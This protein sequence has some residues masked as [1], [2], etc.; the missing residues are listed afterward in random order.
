MFAE[1][2]VERGRLRAILPCS[3]GTIIRTETDTYE[4]PGCH[5]LPG[6]VDNHAHIVGLGERLLVVSLHHAISEDD[7][8]EKL[9]MAGP[10]PNGWIRAMGWNQEQ[11]PNAQWPSIAR[12]DAAFPTTPVSASRVDGH[13]MWVN[14]AALKAA[15]IDAHGHSGLLIDDDMAPVFAAI[16]PRTND[17]LRSMILAATSLCAS[18]GITEIHDM[19]VAEPWLDPFRELAEQGALP[20]RVQSFVRAHSDEWRIAGQLPAIGEFVRLA[21]VKYYA[22]GALGSRGALL[23]AP[24]HDDVSTSGLELL[25]V[26]EM[27][28]KANEAIEAGWPCIAIHAIGDAA[29]RNVL[30][31]Y[32]LIRSTP[33]GADVI[34]RIEHAQHVHPDDVQRMA[35]L[36]VIACVQPSHCMSDAAMAERRLGPERLSWA[37]RWRSLLDAGVHLGAGSDFPIESPDVLAGIAAF[38]K[39][40]PTGSMDAWQ[41]QECITTKEAI[42]AYTLWAHRTTGM[43]YRR[44]RLEVGY[45]ADVVVLDRDLETSTADEIASTTVMATFVAGKRRYTS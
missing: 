42:L 21:G 28:R 18:M 25:S 43:D 36:G 13:A 39:R 32:E 11:W 37:Y 44:G 15:G 27:F 20:V 9:R 40:T 10:Q 1:L 16:P 29:V 19:D 23:R 26:E 4:Y 24:Y 41:G 38:I 34:L 8:V 14:S 30:D 33:N 7:C 12:L 22:D 17:D 35:R 45:D 5:V 6:F 2:H 31:A 3:I